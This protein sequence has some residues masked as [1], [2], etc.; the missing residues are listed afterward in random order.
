MTIDHPEPNETVPFGTFR[1]DPRLERLLS[2]TQTCGQGWLS[3]RLAFALRALGVAL[4]KGKPAD[5]ERMGARFRLYP[6]R[7]V[8]E[9]R[10]LF[11]PDYFDR[12]EREFLASRIGPNFVFLDIGANVGGYSMAMAALAGPGSRILAV[13]PQPRIFERLIFN[14]GQNPFGTVKAVDCAVADR[15]GEVTLFID[16]R[17]QGESSVKIVGSTGQ[18][19]LKVPARTLLDLVTQEGVD[20]VDAIKIDVEGAEDL[21]LEPYF[22]EAPEALWPKAILMENSVGVWQIDLPK[23]LNEKGYRPVAM[24]RRNLAYVR[25]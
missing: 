9:K 21:I 4:L 7:N 6:D 5:V 22:R 2:I 8:C 16:P 14:I 25:D 11:T 1:P 3:R 18:T 13:E 12:T 23:L 20:H 15:N 19:Q 17:N 24:M 10:I